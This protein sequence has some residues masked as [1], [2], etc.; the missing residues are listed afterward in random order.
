MLVTPQL[1]T[2]LPLKLTNTMQFVHLHV[3]YT[4]EYEYILTAS[5]FLYMP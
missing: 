4:N 1:L 5:Y 3:N 2:L